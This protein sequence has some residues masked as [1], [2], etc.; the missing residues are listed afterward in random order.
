MAKKKKPVAYIHNG[1]AHA[2][3]EGPTE[4]VSESTI[5]DPPREEKEQPADEKPAV[6]VCEAS[7][8]ADVAGKAKAE[9]P[10][11]HP[12]VTKAKAALADLDASHASNIPIPQDD[13]ALADLADKMA[14]VKPTA[15]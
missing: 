15:D 1:V 12:A 5:D 8:D 10:P 3:E 14:K 9:A 7:F 2:G 13:E 4:Y 11:E 6:T